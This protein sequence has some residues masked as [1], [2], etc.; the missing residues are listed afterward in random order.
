M[1]TP[2]IVKIAAPTSGLGVLK[3]VPPKTKLSV[4]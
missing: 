2:P 1:L 3:L 4:G